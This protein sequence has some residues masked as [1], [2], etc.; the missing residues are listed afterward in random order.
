MYTV[1]KQVFFCYGHRLM[2]YEGKCRHPHGHNGRVEIELQ[3]DRLDD[4]GMV[5]DFSEIGRAMKGWIDANLD[6][7]MLLRGDDPL[8]VALEK[9]G[10][11]VF[12]MTQNPTAEAIAQLIYEQVE[13]QGF[14]VTE[15]RLWETES[16][17]AAYRGGN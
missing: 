8:V 7:R 11:P 6:H 15:V 3:A 2:N 5:Q 13:Q 1:T 10:E 14:P 17:F 16:S 4:K 9:L 12:L